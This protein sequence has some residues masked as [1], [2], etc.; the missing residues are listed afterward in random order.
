[1]EIPYLIY[2]SHNFC[3]ESGR[4]NEGLPGPGRNVQNE[5]KKKHFRKHP[6]AALHYC[7]SPFLQSWIKTVLVWKKLLAS[8]TAWFFGLWYGSFPSS[9]MCPSPVTWCWWHFLDVYST[10]RASKRNWYGQYLGDLI[11]HHLLSLTSVSCHHL[12][13]CCMDIFTSASVFNL[14]CF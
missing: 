7:F 14:E 4:K 6:V 5:T 3:F 1:M 10:K 2:H 11:C 8:Q 12:C 9:E 13:N